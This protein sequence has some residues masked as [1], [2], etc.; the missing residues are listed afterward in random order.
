MAVTFGNKVVK[1][2]GLVFSGCLLPGSFAT[3]VYCIR[4]HLGEITSSV[5]ISHTLCIQDFSHIL[6]TRLASANPARNQK[7]HPSIAC[8]S[9][10]SRFRVWPCSDLCSLIPLYLGKS[11][12]QTTV[13]E[14]SVQLMPFQPPTCNAK[15]RRLY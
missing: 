9:V 14:L 7:I 6:G 8:S 15:K 1:E 4:K 2:L 11:T 10:N 3:I 12:P 5:S 13:K